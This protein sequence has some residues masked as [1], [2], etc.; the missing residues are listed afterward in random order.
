MDRIDRD[1]VVRVLEAVIDVVGGP[2]TDV[3]W[4]GYDDPAEVVADLR[5][6]SRRV[7]PPGPDRG[8]VRQ[9]SLLF[10]PTGAVQEIS[11]SSGWGD[12]FLGLA[13]RMDRAL[14]EIDW[15]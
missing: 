1:E 5:G 15:G 13:D 9:I 6:L 10:A 8:T 12:E 2:D 3:S 14:G 11:I 7:R 4:S